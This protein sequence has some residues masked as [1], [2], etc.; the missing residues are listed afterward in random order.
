MPTEIISTTAA[1]EA[2]GPEWDT[3]W[4]NASDA[5]PF[6]SPHWLLPWWKHFGGSEP[7]V[8]LQREGTTLQA[9]APLYILRDDD[10]DESLGLLLGTGISDYL[11]LLSLPSVAIDGVLA[12]IGQSDCQLWDFQQ[13]R[14]TSL[15]ATAAAPAG[16]TD[17]VEDHDTCPLLSLRDA[18]HDFENL[19]SVHARKKLRYYT[20]AL[21]RIGPLAFERATDANLDTLLTALFDLHA[22]RW[23]Q[24]G[25]PGVLADDVVQQFH[26]DVAR[27]MLHAGALRM[28]ALSVKGV[29]AAVF[30]GFAHQATTCYYLSGYDPQ[31]EKQ[32]IGTVLVSHAVANAIEEGQTTFDF[33]RGAEDYKYSW[34][35]VDRINRHR[36]LIRN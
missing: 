4:R 7:H 6:Q 21:S 30:Y 10:S 36:S 12:A 27:R 35:A 22:A 29:P 1:L 17:S 19:L 13:L 5:T 20:R 8:V 33:L 25:L 23:K 32:S 26:R 28:F 14:P 34:G 24:R 15:L 9:L 16:W 3:L 18:N 2:L 31:Y 11:D